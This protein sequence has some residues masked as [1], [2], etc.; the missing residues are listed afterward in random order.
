MC[1]SSGPR[2][3]TL[4]PVAAEAPRLPDVNA[5]LASRVAA[6]RRTAGGVGGTILTGPRGVT[7]SATLG[8][9]T[10]LGQ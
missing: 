4:P 10:L 7:E 3:P 5:S 2:A 1:L 6:R 8:T 9:Q